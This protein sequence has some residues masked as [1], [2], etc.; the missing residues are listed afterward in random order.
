MILATATMFAGHAIADGPLQWNWIG[1]NKRT[2]GWRGPTALGLHGLTH[3][4]FVWAAT[5]MLALGLAEAA[6][7]A[8]IDGLK[9]R[10]GFG[11]FTDQ[12][13]HAACKVV[14]LVLFWVNA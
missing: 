4:L 2:A 10:L 7:H 8:V 6:A 11:P 14:W 9:P 12:M 13:L 1:R 5:G 3:G